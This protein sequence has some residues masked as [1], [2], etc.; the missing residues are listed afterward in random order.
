L[1]RAG[2]VAL[3]LT[4]AVSPALAAPVDAAFMAQINAAMT[5]M[6]SG[7]DVAPTG[8][9]DADFVATMV[10]HHQG[11]IEMAESELRYGDNERLQRLS[12]GQPLPPSLPA[13]DAIP[14][15]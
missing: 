15:H 12:L 8:D 7:M 4:L 11:A 2:P 9:A 14:K 1:E 5:K 10:P 13:P 6:M 3:C